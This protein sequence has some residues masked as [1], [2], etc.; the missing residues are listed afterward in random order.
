MQPQAL[1]AE[2][3]PGTPSPQGPFAREKKKKKMV[4]KVMMM[5]KSED[6]INPT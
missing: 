5:I 4:V 2:A 6:M 3:H 1:A